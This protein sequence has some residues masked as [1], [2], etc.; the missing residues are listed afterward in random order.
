MLSILTRPTITLHPLSW[1]EWNQCLLAA[2]A[3]LGFTMPNKFLRV[4]KLLRRKSHSRS[5]LDD[6]RAVGERLMG[7]LTGSRCPSA[8]TNRETRVTCCRC[9]RQRYIRPLRRT[10]SLHCRQVDRW[11]GKMRRR[12]T[13][14][15][16][17]F[18]WMRVGLVFPGK[19]LAELPA[20]LEKRKTPWPSQGGQC[21]ALLG[22]KRLPVEGF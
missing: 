7:R 21:P 9:H 20:S 10:G 11:N 16:R 6:Y 3:N 19:G 15:W 1:R 13:P 12:W 4:Q 2:L 22:R 14:S 8:E 17:A 18:R 5:S